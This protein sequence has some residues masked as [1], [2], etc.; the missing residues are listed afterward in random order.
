MPKE[1]QNFP[2]YYDVLK[3]HI[4]R[5]AASVSPGVSSNKTEDTGVFY[6]CACA[7]A[8]ACV[9]V[10]VCVCVSLDVASSKTDQT[11][12]FVCVC[13]C[14]SRSVACNQTEDEEV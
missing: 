6:V 10:R 11:G 8:C 2:Q 5:V 14:L 12:A 13:M 3:E 7:C 1:K 4:E 9:R